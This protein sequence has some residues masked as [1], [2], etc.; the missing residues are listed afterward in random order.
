MQ[1]YDEASFKVIKMIAKNFHQVM[2]IGLIRDQYNEIPN[3][4]NTSRFGK[5]IKKSQDE[6][7]IEGIVTIESVYGKESL[8]SII[9]RGL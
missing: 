4:A 5:G 7:F 9:L 3:N 1:Y 6:I 2:C 8:H